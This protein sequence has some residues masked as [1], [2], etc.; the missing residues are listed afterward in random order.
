MNHVPPKCETKLPSSLREK[1]FAEQVC[2]LEFPNDNR[3]HVWFGRIPR[4]KDIDCVIWFP[5]HGLF[6]VELKSWALSNIIEVSSDKIRLQESVAH[7][8][9]K[10]PWQQARE[11]AFSLKNR[12]ERDRDCRNSLGRFWLAS[13]VG[14]YNIS[15]QAF[16]ERFLSKEG[17]SGEEGFRNTISR[18]TLFSEDLVSGNALLN[19]L[20][21]AKRK[22]VFGAGA[23]FVQDTQNIDSNAVIRALNGVLHPSL[24]AGQNASAYDKERVRS[25]E[26]YEAKVLDKLNWTNPVICTG[27][28]GTGK[29]IL[30]L[31]SALRRLRKR[32]GRGLFIC[33]NKVLATDIDRLLQLSPVYATVRLDVFDIFQFLRALAQDANIPYS[34]DPR[35]VDLS[36][37]GICNGLFEKWNAEDPGTGPKYDFVVVDEAQD[38]R[39]WAWSLIDKVQGK[40]SE[41]MIIDAKD[42]Q[43]YCTEKA[44]YL[45]EL[46]DL[47]RK[48]DR[49][50]YIEKRRVFRTTDTS[51]LLSQL[52]VDSYPNV[53]HARN[54]WNQFYGPHYAGAKH[55]AR[56]GSDNATLFELPRR[57]GRAP[58]LHFCKP[59]HEEA[60]QM[61]ADLLRKA[62]NNTSNL[63]R[64]DQPCGVLILVPFQE[65]EK[66]R[67]PNWNAVAREAC[68]SC[69]LRFI[70][71]S[72]DEDDIRRRAYS[73]D[74]V[75]ISTF[76]SSKG[77]EGL[78]VIVLGFDALS[79]VA[80]SDVKRGTNN[81][82]YIVL[83]RSQYDTDVVCLDRNVLHQ[84]TKFLESA[85]EIVG[86]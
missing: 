57:H 72:N 50:N 13:A 6:A 60:V 24:I 56:G 29:T 64:D 63:F 23:R 71:Y 10:T 59:S 18:A 12:L 78:H 40:D 45:I 86:N 16:E 9:K 43:L 80:P 28:A 37:K 58:E 73:G 51:F 65:R 27:Y 7:S 42:Q 84:E 61:T 21:K 4:S 53:A 32:E 20:L 30:G 52:F 55:I 54:R 15:R 69:N 75:R 85:I 62:V 26:T 48:E 17:V 41:L 67:F 8:T 68:Q 44:D 36:A 2:S 77:I 33:F 11:E 82:G 81:L 1:P 74:E 31:Q 19:R 35:N 22:P 34:F 76:H 49:G 5:K 79:D 70:D 38:L 14:L 47:V 66:T 83:S 46:T 3:P 25:L 39:E